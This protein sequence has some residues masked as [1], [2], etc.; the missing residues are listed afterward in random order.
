MPMPAPSVKLALLGVFI[1][2]LKLPGQE[3]APPEDPNAP[4]P[5]APALEK[6]AAPEDT[7]LANLPESVRATMQKLE[8]FRTERSAKLNEDIAA[9]RKNAAALMTRTAAT[10]D[11]A[12]RVQ[13]LD[14]AKRVS[15]L[16]PELPLTEADPTKPS[17]ATLQLAV[18]WDIPSSTSKYELLAD[19]T[20]N[21]GNLVVKWA[22]FDEAR[23][24]CYIDY[25]DGEFAEFAQIVTPTKLTLFGMDGGHFSFTREEA[26]AIP[27]AD[28]KK[29]EPTP[30]L[31]KLLTTEA[32]L[33]EAF[34]ASIQATEKKV[35]S[36]LTQQASTLPNDTR[37][38]VLALASRLEK[39]F[40]SLY[41]PAVTPNVALA[42]AWTTAGKTLEF[43]PGGGLIVNGKK[44]GNWTW[45]KQK[46]QNVV[47][48]SLGPKDTIAYGLLKP[49]LPAEM[50]I[51]PIIGKLTDAV[52][53][54]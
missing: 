30:A 4:P 37:P 31:V 53:K 32:T 48:F 46:K 39:G 1:L 7:A 43:A 21:L 27:A 14:D 34:N 5:E 29:A 17:P 10:V 49:N 45:P 25:V 41:P 23:K 54:P 47:L 16:A 44:Q 6:P 42:G 36:F 50:K 3:P 13:L 18:P 11:A 8:Q 2:T 38:A 9:A 52:K 15:E 19:G 35:A 24:I 26:A 51:Y 20:A 28:A 22:W 12:R 40:T 33:H